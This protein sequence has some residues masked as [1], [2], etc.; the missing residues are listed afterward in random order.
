MKQFH[1]VI[2]GYKV[3]YYKSDSKNELAILFVH[4]LGTGGRIWFNQMMHLREYATLYAVDLPGIIGP[5]PPFI[6][7]LQDYSIFI[8]RFLDFMEIEQAIG[9][10]YSMGGKF[11]MNAYFNNPTRFR[12]I[13]L[14]S[15]Q[16]LLVSGY[17][18]LV[19][20]NYSQE[21]LHKVV[22]Y[23]SERFPLISHFSA[24]ISKHRQDRNLERLWEGVKKEYYNNKIKQIQL[25][26]AII[27][28][29]HDRVV[30]LEHG[31]KYARDIPNAKLTI[32]EKSAHVPMLEQPKAVS[33]A[34]L[35]LIFRASSTGNKTALETENG[36]FTEFE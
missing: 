35:E 24:A 34:L 19:T 25:P 11:I 7:T 16:G 23:E 31:Y 8:H 9:V 6:N 14:I 21:E 5:I 13:G 33:R 17:P 3:N 26:V 2:E 4:G 10:G 12:G 29:R 22:Y 30:P 36:Y 18:T 15:S 28:G 1:I 27:W 20:K 32:A